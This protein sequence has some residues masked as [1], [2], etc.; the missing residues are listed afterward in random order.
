[1]PLL[2]PCSART[3]CYR[4][5]SMFLWSRRAAVS[6]FPSTPVSNA[7]HLPAPSLQKQKQKDNSG[8][9]QMYWCLSRKS[10][11]RTHCQNNTCNEQVQGSLQKHLWQAGATV[12]AETKTLVNPGAVVNHWEVISLWTLFCVRHW[13]DKHC[14]GRGVK[15]INLE[16]SSYDLSLTFAIQNLGGWKLFCLM[17]CISVSTP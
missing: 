15:S 12:D 8:L 16:P 9:K 14:Y 4:A 5:I 10:R 1:M 13:E 6:A 7:N 11:R 2:S 3:I 17:W